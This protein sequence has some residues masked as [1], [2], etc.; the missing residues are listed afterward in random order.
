MEFEF[1]INPETV[2][3][4]MPFAAFAQGRFWHRATFRG[5]APLRQLLRV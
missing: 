2:P 3:G 1:V 4:P 5:G